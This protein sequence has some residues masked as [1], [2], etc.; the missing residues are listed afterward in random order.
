MNFSR[1]EGR[2][3]VP[4]GLF[5]ASDKETARGKDAIVVYGGPDNQARRGMPLA[6][7]LVLCALGGLSA[8][9]VSPV[10]CLLVGFGALAAGA[11]GSRRLHA[12]V[13]AGT[14]V[15]S[16]LGGAFFGVESVPDALVAALVGLASALL[17]EKR[18]MTPG[19]AC[20]VA[21][22]AAAAHI[23]IAEAFALAGQT[24]LADSFAGL[25]SGNAQLFEAAGVDPETLTVVQK[26]VGILWP[27]VFSTLAALELLCAC[28]GAAL[29]AARL[30][31]REVEVPDFGLFDLPLWVVAIFVAAV[32]GLAA[33]FTQPSLATDELLM[34][35]GNALLT[36]R[37][38]LAAQGMAVLVWR[39]RNRKASQLAFVF[40]VAFAA[41]LEAQFIVMSF[42]GLLDVWANLRRL[43]RGEQ[44]GS[45]DEA[46]QD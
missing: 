38:A 13:I 27:A 30:R 43:P 26:A 19:A 9:F 2:P 28:V 4:E 32:V 15:L 8:G 17:V 22:A 29:A 37:Y 33:W 40:A 34:V 14:L 46:K 44:E 18:R 25:V 39:L 45:Q 24:T 10:A 16:G 42:V 20:L 12:A 35:A 23:G 3:P 5:S 31:D 11:G 36:V 21:L 1:E 6:V 7:A 41:Y